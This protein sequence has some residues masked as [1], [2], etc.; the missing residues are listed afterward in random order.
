[1]DGSWKGRVMVI[2]EWCLAKLLTPLKQVGPFN[3]SDDCSHVLVP[4]LDLNLLEDRFLFY[5]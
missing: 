5:V 1:M 3:V 4:L 2:D